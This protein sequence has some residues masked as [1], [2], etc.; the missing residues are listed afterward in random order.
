MPVGT[1]AVAPIEVL[2]NVP[3]MSRKGTRAIS[4]VCLRSQF[5]VRHYELEVR[6]LWISLLGGQFGFDADDS[7]SVLFPYM[8]I[9][10]FFTVFTENAT[11][12]LQYRPCFSIICLPW[13]RY[14][15]CFNQTPRSENVAWTR[16]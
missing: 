9:N 3:S 4:F 13:L 5:T 15:R 10:S 16:K 14:E 11:D 1:T 12:Y 6:T 2:S 8:P 7:S